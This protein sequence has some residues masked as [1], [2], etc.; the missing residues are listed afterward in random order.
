[1]NFITLEGSE[2]RSVDSQAITFD[3]V[4]LSVNQKMD[5][6]HRWRRLLTREF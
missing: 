5:K 6:C 4:F 3:P 2:I 1:M